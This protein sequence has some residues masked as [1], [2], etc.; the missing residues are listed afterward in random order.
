MEN[1]NNKNQNDY[2]SIVKDLSNEELK[3]Y[4]SVILLSVKNGYTTAENSYLGKKLN[5][6]REEIKDIISSLI[7]R[8]TIYYT[9]T[10]EGRQLFY[11]INKWRNTKKENKKSESTASVPSENKKSEN[12]NAKDEALNQKVEEKLK[13]L[14]PGE[15]FE[16]HELAE[17]R[18]IS[19]LEKLGI[20]YG[21]NQKAIFDTLKTG[22]MIMILKE[23][24]KSNQTL[25]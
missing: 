10:E 15:E 5:M 14:D 18:Y 6:T 24:I 7:K 22:Y 12:I 17:E 21:K 2:L 8:K 25:N 1:K 23:Q 20:I 16:L 13:K 9:R 3:V 19:D 11:N 4:T